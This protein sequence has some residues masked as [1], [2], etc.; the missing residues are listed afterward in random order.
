MLEKARP[1]LTP[2]TT[3]HIAQPSFVKAFHSRSSSGNPSTLASSSSDLGFLLARSASCNRVVI[4]PSYANSSTLFLSF[5][6]ISSRSLVL[7]LV[8]VL[9]LPGLGPDSRVT[10]PN[11]ASSILLSKA[12]M[13]ARRLQVLL[14]MFRK[15]D[16]CN[17][18]I[19]RISW[20]LHRKSASIIDF[21]T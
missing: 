7:V 21:T 1:T 13:V 20:G 6:S 10:G 14:G 2:H 18:K 8:L 9:V 3:A 11:W 16:R 4:P 12:D 17:L 19:D 5:A 15:L